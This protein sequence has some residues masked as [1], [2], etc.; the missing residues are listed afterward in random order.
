MEFLIGFSFFVKSSSLALAQGCLY[1][2]QMLSQVLIFIK[3]INNYCARLSKI[4]S[5]VSGEQIN[6]L[7]KQNA[8]ANY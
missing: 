5:F 7:P 1:E 6:Y 3:K 8:E 4:S 2:G